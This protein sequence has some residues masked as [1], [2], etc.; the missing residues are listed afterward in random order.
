MVTMQRSFW[1]LNQIK[2]II[3]RSV[4]GIYNYIVYKFVKEI[5][6]KKGTI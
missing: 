2:Y 4:F 5:Y 3:G 6:N 1:Q